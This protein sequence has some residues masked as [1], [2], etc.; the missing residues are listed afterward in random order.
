MSGVNGLVGLKVPPTR[1]DPCSLH[2]LGR[3]CPDSSTYTWN[4]CEL[5]RNAIPV[6]I[7]R[8][9]AKTE[10]LNP[11]GRTMS[12]PVSGL[13][14]ATSVGQIGFATVAARAAGD[15]TPIPAKTNAAATA[16]S[17]GWRKN[18]RFG[19]AERRFIAHSSWK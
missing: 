19:K 7:F 6:G 12:P 11:G 15:A 4:C 5:P 8:P 14:N 16:L 1:G 10:T 13:N 3:P 18:R 17:L 9:E 2:M